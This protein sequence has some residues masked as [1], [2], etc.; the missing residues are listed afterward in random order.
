[1]KKVFAL[2]IACLYL[3]V[4]SGLAVQIH[5]C[6]GKVSGVTLVPSNKN[7]CGKCGMEKGANKCCKD[8]LKLVKLQDS[9]KLS[10]AEYK[11]ALP[12]IDLGTHYHLAYLPFIHQAPLGE[13]NS[14]SPPFVEAVPL[15]IMNCIFR[16]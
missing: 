12:Q 11:L 8:E 1:M 5:H 6:M 2:L 7:K 10:T 14:H 4:S 3:A 13:Y 16:V 15:C 9:Y